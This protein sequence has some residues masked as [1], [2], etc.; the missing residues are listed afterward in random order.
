MSPLRRPRRRTARVLPREEGAAPLDLVIAVMAF[1]AALAVGAVLVANRTAESWQAGLAGKLTVQ[2]LPPDAGPPGPAMARETAAALKVLNAT[3]GIVTAAPLS[4]AETQK[5]V[6]PWL[7][8]GALVA[9]LPLPRMIDATVM[10]GTEIDVAAL[11]RRLQAA[12]PDTTLDDHR[13]WLARLSGVAGTV[14]WSAYGIL[15]LIALATAA[16]VAFAT[17]AGLQAHREI[18]ELLHQMGAHAGFI[19]RAFDGHYLLATLAA[20]AAGAGL[21]ALL[22]VLAASLELAGVEAVPFLPPLALSLPELA[23]LATVPLAAGLI[24]WGTARAS[25]LAALREIY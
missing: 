9:D 2:V 20:S 25:V 13:H 22:F 11:R 8:K 14:I 12:A 7:G 23:W 19:A 6:E 16:T 18:V 1:L 4:E 15:A 21:A 5:L 24:A 3:A 17:R 10:P